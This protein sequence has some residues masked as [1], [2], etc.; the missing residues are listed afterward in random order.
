MSTPLLGPK[1]KAELEAII[2]ACLEAHYQSHGPDTL[3][4]PGITIVVRADGVTIERGAVTHCLAQIEVRQLFTALCYLAGEAG[5][6]VMPR[7]A[8]V[9]FATE[10]TSAT[11]AQINRLM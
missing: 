1:E 2:R 7:D 3:L 4:E 8:L 6:I 11:A 10:A 9:T 5:E